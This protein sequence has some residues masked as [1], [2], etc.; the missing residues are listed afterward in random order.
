MDIRNTVIKLRDG[1]KELSDRVAELT[2]ELK[3]F[4]DEYDTL[5]RVLGVKIECLEKRVKK[6][7]ALLSL[8]K[9]L[10]KRTDTVCSF[11]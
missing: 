7:L 9:L 8:N 10:C 2:V 3:S 1:Q 4:K 11:H 6:V 5:H